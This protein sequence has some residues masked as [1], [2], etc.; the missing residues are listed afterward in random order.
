MTTFE[1][2]QKRLNCLRNHQRTICDAEKPYYAELRNIERKFL[3]Q[4]QSFF[5][6]RAQIVNGK[7]QPTTE[8]AE[9][10][11]AGQV[12]APYVDF[13]SSAS[14]GIPLFWLTVLKNSSDISYMIEDWDEPALKYLTDIRGRYADEGYGFTVEFHFSPNEFFSNSVLSV[15]YREKCDFVPGELFDIQMGIVDCTGTTINWKDNKNLTKMK[16]TMKNKKTGDKKV[17]IDKVPSFFDFFNP[18]VVEADSKDAE[19]Q[20]DKLEDNYSTG[21]H[22][23]EN[24]IPYAVL[25]Y[26]EE[27]YDSSDSEESETEDSEEDSSESEDERHTGRKKHVRKIRQ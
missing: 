22:F 5:E 1:S 13:K 23:M 12:S 21:V 10:K 14:S 18:P 24:V 16:K 11:L 6:Q 27:M 7:R 8:E 25:Y 26:T 4:N 3:L 15:T 17:K 19:E 9:W 2:V 20:Q